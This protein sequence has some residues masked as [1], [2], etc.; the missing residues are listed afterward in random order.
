MTDSQEEEK[1][2]PVTGACLCRAVRFE[3]APPSM[4]CAHCHCT[5]CRRAHGAG[6]VTWFSVT[7]EQLDVVEGEAHLVRYKSSE[8]GTRSFCGLCGSSL[9]FTTEEDPGRFDL[10]LANMDGPIDLAPQAHVFFEGRV[11]WVSVDDALPRLGGPTGIE[12]I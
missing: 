11:D 2:A 4:F 5:M 10:V 9:F 12:P 6:Y 8:H 1:G 7:P 3:V